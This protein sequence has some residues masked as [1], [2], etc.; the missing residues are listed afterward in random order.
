M[1]S[2]CCLIPNTINFHH[3]NGNY[4][5]CSINEQRLLRASSRTIC[6]GQYKSRSLPHTKGTQQAT[7]YEIF[8]KFSI[9]KFHLFSSWRYT[10]TICWL[11]S[12]LDFL[13]DAWHIFGVPERYLRLPSATAHLSKGRWTDA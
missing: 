11:V 4:A 9:P 1:V 7:C 12:F 3:Y 10:C 2:T 5:Y 13:L 8:I 6:H